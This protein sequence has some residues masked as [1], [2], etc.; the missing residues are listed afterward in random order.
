MKVEQLAKLVIDSCRA[1]QV[2]YM[3][4][5]AFAVAFYGIPRSTKDVDFVINLIPSDALQRLIRNL[6]TWVDFESQVQFDTLTWGRRHIGKP[7]AD[8]G[9][10]VELFELFDDPF[11]KAQF[12]RKIQIR[13]QQLGCETWLPTAED[14]VIQ[15]LRWGRP[16]DLEDVKDILAVQGPES[17]DMDYVRNWC[18]SH[19]TA[20]R[21]LEML[22][23]IPPI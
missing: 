14:V 7:K 23:A 3:M 6:E 15:K 10:K 12:A 20:E 17:L 22:K 4:T 5:G 21:L 9:L 8:T 13:S 16:K 19:G 1:E 18:C 11:V 2:D